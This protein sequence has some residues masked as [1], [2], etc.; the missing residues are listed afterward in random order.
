MLSAAKLMGEHN[1]T[2]A[3]MIPSVIYH[4][5]PHSCISIG[6]KLNDSNISNRLYRYMRFDS[7]DISFCSR[8][9][10]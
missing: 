9:L 2:T 4:L 1:N 3:D 7:Q 6:I 10:M 8:R 5:V